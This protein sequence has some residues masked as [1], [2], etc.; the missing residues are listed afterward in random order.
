MAYVRLLIAFIGAL[1]LLPPVGR[2][3]TAQASRQ[4]TPHVAAHLSEIVSVIQRQ[5]L[6]RARM[7]WMSFE[8]QMFDRAA[9]AT[10]IADAQDA[11]RVGLS[12]LADKHSY[13]IRPDGSLVFNPE[14]PTQSTGECTPTEFAPVATPPDIGYLRATITPPTPK[15]DIQDAL[16]KM[17]GPRVVGWIVDLRNSR[18]GN[19]WPAIAGLGTLLGEGTAGF[20]IDADDTA[21]P[22]GFADGAAFLGEQSIDRLISPHRLSSTGRVAVLT[23]TGVASSG[24]AVAVAFRA[25][26]NTRS[27][28][29]STCGLSTAVNQFPLKTGG[30]IALVVATMA[31]RTKT[32]YGGKIPPDELIEDPSR[33]VSRA[34]EWLRRQ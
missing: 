13:Y 17:D 24:E 31:D 11:I 5:W 22:W 34:V 27:F 9:G 16:R 20:F 18:G 28:G 23:D 33:L 7:D 2:R 19:M 15:E 25:R 10:T 4:L 3:A 6:F 21:T 26:P 1:L 8:R 29:T 30:R 32:K 12:M 14:S